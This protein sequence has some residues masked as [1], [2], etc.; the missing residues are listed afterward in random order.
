MSV[1][2]LKQIFD[3]KLGEAGNLQAINCY[4][5]IIIVAICLFSLI[6]VKK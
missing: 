1:S 2:T 5:L 3:Q 6:K 4:Q